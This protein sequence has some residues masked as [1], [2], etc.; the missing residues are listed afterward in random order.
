M[1]LE[2]LDFYTVYRLAVLLARNKEASDNTPVANWVAMACVSAVTD[3]GVSSD[4]PVTVGWA[5]EL[6]HRGFMRS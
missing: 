2:D 6:F 3:L 1:V 4:R 5:R